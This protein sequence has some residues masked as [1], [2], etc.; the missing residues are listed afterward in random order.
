MGREMRIDV[1]KHLHQLVLVDRGLQPGFPKEKDPLVEA[2]QTSP[3]SHHA[4]YTC[5]FGPTRNLHPKNLAAPAAGNT[6]RPPFAHIM[7]G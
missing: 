4:W 2:T 6:T 5:M 1:A 3:N 7:F